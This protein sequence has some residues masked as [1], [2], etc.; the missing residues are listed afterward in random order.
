MSPI[1]P[2]F[3]FRI[4]SAYASTVQTMIHYPT[5]AKRVLE[6]AERVF[7]INTVDKVLIRAW[8]SSQ[9]S[10][11]AHCQHQCNH[12]AS[13][14]QHPPS[15]TTYQMA[16]LDGSGE[17]EGRQIMVLSDEW[18]HYQGWWGAVLQVRIWQLHINISTGYFFL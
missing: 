18:L 1:E 8:M 2:L 13:D 7:W 12:S 6:F 4:V 14:P 9:H 16:R 3:I 10:R 15:L 5:R 17:V 11:Q